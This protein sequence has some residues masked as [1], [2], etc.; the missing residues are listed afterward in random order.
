MSTRNAKK[1]IA[2]TRPTLD[3]LD[4]SSVALTGLEVEF[5]ASPSLLADVYES[6]DFRLSWDNE[7]SFHVANHVIH[8]RQYRGYSQLR[9]ASAMGTSQSK[10]ARI[11]GGD[12]NITLKT[13]KRIAAAL[14]GRLRL[15]IEP[16]E[17]LFPRM[18]DWW[19]AIS[20]DLGRLRADPLPHIA[21]PHA[22]VAQD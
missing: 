8:L 6:P 2:K 7:A 1:R 15:A 10:V 18:P 3:T 20:L 19:D 22:P 17:I 5:G 12:E 21:G 14:K 11:E 16:Q 9:V 13:L 4:M